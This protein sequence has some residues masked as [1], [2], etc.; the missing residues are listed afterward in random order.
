MKLGWGQAWTRFHRYADDAI[1]HCRTQSEAESLRAALAER[2]AACG[3]AL[4]PQ[5]TKTVYCD[6][7]NRS[8][9]YGRL[10]ISETQPFRALRS[11]PGRSCLY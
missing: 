5:K 7:T 4:H 1:C 11:T 2:F 6:D 8:G 3:L 10:K 9:R